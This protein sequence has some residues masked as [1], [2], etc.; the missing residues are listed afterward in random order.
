ML[1]ISLD[2]AKGNTIFGEYFSA[3]LR[4]A[5]ARKSSGRQLPEKPTG[6]SDFGF[7]KLPVWVRIGVLAIIPAFILVQIASSEPLISMPFHAGD[8]EKS[9]KEEYA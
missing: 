4:P 1:K 6:P 7:E 5:R 9:C 3:L 2:L 8:K